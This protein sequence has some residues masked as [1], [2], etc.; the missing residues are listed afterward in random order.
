[1]PTASLERRGRPSGASSHRHH[2]RRHRGQHRQHAG[3][4]WTSRALQRRRRCN[5]RGGQPITVPH[6]R[7]IRAPPRFAP[8]AVSWPRPAAFSPTTRRDD[9]VLLRHHHRPLFHNVRHHAA[10]S[11][12]HR[13]WATVRARE[14]SRVSPGRRKAKVYGGGG[15][16]GTSAVCC[17]LYRVRVRAL[18]RVYY[19]YYYCNTVTDRARAANVIFSR[20]SARVGSLRTDGPTDGR[21]NGR[22]VGG[23]RR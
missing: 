11:S 10:A 12:G 21:S 17:G 19:Y 16:G 14:M 3:P 2:R 22:P 15:G 13:N 7:A 1:M 8:L 4:S 23:T 6:C 9:G 20:Y 18:A 5:S